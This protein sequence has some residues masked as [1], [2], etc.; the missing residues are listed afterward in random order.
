MYK[1]VDFSFR[2]N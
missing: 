2:L 1:I